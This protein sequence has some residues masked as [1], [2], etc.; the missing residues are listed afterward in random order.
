MVRDGFT[1]AGRRNLTKRSVTLEKATG[2]GVILGIK[3]GMGMPLWGAPVTHSASHRI[4]P[5]IRKIFYLLAS[6][7]SN[8]MD[9]KILLEGV[10]K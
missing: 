5:C 9:F 3:S 1:K 8:R 10:K 6:M 7:K 4:V 2:G